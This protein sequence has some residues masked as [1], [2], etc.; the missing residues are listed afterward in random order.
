MAKPGAV[1]QRPQV[2]RVGCLRFWYDN[3][4]GQP[5]R[6]C[7]LLDIWVKLD[8]SI[9]QV[10]TGGVPFS[11]LTAE[12]AFMIAV[13]MGERPSKIPTESSGGI[14]YEN[15]WDVAAACWP[16]DAADR[17]TMSEAFHRIQADPSLTESH[18]LPAFVSFVQ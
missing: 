6:R 11:D 8:F 7:L 12:G 16:G 18:R 17:I 14:S 5:F 4:R 2:L 3:H 10:L 15:I 9:R 1:G 13:M